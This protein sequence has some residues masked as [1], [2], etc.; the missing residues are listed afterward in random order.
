MD[1][2]IQDGD[3][4]VTI[5]NDGATILDK[6]EIHHQ[7]GKILIQLSKSQDDEIGDGTT[8][9]VILA[10]ALLETAE[11]LIDMGIHP[12]QIAEGYDSGCTIAIDH[13]KKIATSFDF[14]DTQVEP[15]VKICM[16]SLS[17]K[18]VKK[19]KR[20][21]AE[22]CVRAL[23]AI[24]DIKRQEVNLELIKIECKAGGKLE[25]ITLVN[26]IVLDKT[27]SHS[28]MKKQIS[29]AK[30]ALLTCAFEPP[31]PKTKHNVEIKSS[32]DFNI[33]YE[34]EQNYFVHMI[35]KI[36]NLGVD[37]V[38][39]QWGFDDEANYLLMHHGITAIRWV[40]GVEVELIAMATG[41]KITPR[42]QELSLDKLGYTKTIRE[43]G[44]GTNQDKVVFIEGCP[45]SRAVTIL[46][47][48]GC[49]VIVD[50]IKRSVHDALCAAKNLMNS[51]VIVYGGGAAE[52]SISL[53]ISSIADLVPGVKQHILRAYAHALEQIPATLA[54][55]SGLNSAELVTTLKAQQLAEGNPYL[56]IDCMGGTQYDMRSNNVFEAFIGKKQQLLLATQACRMILKISD[57]FSTDTGK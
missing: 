32:N 53:K 49:T 15:L 11:P 30:I 36:K 2:L 6:V 51:N 29:N 33:F 25:D 3:G 26:G 31:K 27:I 16:T 28:Q 4:N 47:R 35:Q 22:I 48:G 52:L 40:G 17:P 38:F 46:V 50:E 13:L 24:A 39:C 10:T 55:N 7:I 34:I 43:I 8:G 23:L 44:F 56:G 41:A 20:P 21:L 9:V 57:N 45:R 1:K 54:E 18:I 19:C 14:S 37:A 5:T 12:S 42:F